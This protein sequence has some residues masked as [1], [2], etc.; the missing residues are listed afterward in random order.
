MPKK[1]GITLHIFR[2]IYI[3]FASM[4]DVYRSTQN[5]MREVYTVFKIM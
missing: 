5:K 4:G 3:Y 2:F 1:Y